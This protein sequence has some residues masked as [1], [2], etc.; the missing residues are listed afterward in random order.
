MFWFFCFYV[1]VNITLHTVLVKKYFALVDIDDVICKGLTFLPAKICLLMAG[2]L[3]FSVQTTVVPAMLE[4]YAVVYFLVMLLTTLLGMY[5]GGRFDVARHQVYAGYLAP[6]VF[7]I[8]F[9]TVKVTLS[10]IFLLVVYS[11]L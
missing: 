4:V 6:L 1:I 9:L 11:Q 3:I 2:M 7:L 5:W 8:P 10:A